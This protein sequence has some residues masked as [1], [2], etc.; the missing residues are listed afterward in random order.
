MNSPNCFT[1]FS[2]DGIMEREEKQRE[3]EERER[4]VD[5]EE[6]WSFERMQ[7]VQ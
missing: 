3:T 4:R 6:D 2:E 1:R 5:D 7:R